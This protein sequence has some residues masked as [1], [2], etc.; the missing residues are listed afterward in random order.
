[1]GIV[2]VISTVLD[3]CITYYR[4]DAFSGLNPPNLRGRSTAR[5]EYSHYSA[6]A[7]FDGDDEFPHSSKET[8]SASE[9]TRDELMIEYTRDIGHNTRIVAMLP[10]SRVDQDGYHAGDW[11]VEH[12]WIGTLHMRSDRKISLLLALGLPFAGGVEGLRSPTSD[13]GNDTRVA[14]MAIAASGFQPD[15]S[16]YYARLG[17]VIHLGGGLNDESVYELQ[18]ESHVAPAIGPIHAGLRI[19]AKFTLITDNSES[20]PLSRDAVAV[21]PLI[22]MEISESVGFSM[23][24]RKEVFGYFS[25]AGTSIRAGLD[26]GF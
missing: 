5:V 26:A 2:I 4:A 23:Q 7:Y 16:S 3:G 15:R 13:Q 24:Y 1:L 25:S 9:Y 12:A 19:D 17:G 10:V 11:R 8:M 6:R 14:L 20:T 22:R 21:G 18:G